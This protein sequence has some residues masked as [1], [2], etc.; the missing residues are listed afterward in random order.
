MEERLT[1][2]YAFCAQIYIYIISTLEIRQDITDEVRSKV[3]YS[4]VLVEPF[5][6]MALRHVSDHYGLSAL[7][8]LYT[9]VSYIFKI[10]LNENHHRFFRRTPNI[11]AT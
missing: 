6:T 11:Q 5:A 2:H 9:K 7:K 8:G 3:L 1:G 4:A 10:P